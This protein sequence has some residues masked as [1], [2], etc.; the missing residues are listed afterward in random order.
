MLALK[1]SN[2]QV[3]PLILRLPITAVNTLP[4]V[5]VIYRKRQPV[6]RKN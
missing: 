2:R 3:M 5:I 6:E 1:M 4:I